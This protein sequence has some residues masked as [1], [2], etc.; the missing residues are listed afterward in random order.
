MTSPKIR[1]AA[2]ERALQFLFGLDFTAYDWE[3]V[4]DAF[5]LDNPSKPQVTEYAGMLI[6]GVMTRREELD[7]AIIGAIENWNPERV[8]KIER[9]VLRLALFEARHCDDVP[10][11]VAVNEAIEITK[12][13]GSE[14][15]PRFINGV[16]D[17]LIGNRKQEPPRD[18]S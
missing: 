14:E 7:E 10:P 15:A 4:L 2:R 17:R 13:F 12:R 16:L 9:N 5:W 11:K 1:R 18:T 3:S 8:G 6:K